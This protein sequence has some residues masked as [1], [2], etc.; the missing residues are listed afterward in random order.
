MK[1]AKQRIDAEGEGCAAIGVLYHAI[2][3]SLLLLSPIAPFISESIYQSF[4]RKYEQQESISLFGWPAAE[5]KRRDAL[6]ESRFQ[7]AREIASAAAS[8]R[9]K[10]GIPL[11]WPLEE[12][13][14]VSESTE[15]LSAVEHL[16]ALIESLSNVR[17]VKVG[18]Q[19]KTEISVQINKAKVGAAFKR[20]SPSALAALE[21]AAP[22]EIS[23][24]LSGEDKELVLEGKFAIKKDMVE[25]QE[26]SEGFAISA[27]EGG[28]AFLKTEMKKELYEEAMVREVARRVQLMRKERRLVEPDKISLHIETEDKELLSIL[29]RHTGALSSQVN[30]ETVDFSHHPGGF[31]KEWEIEDAKVRISIEKK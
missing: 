9:Q 23:K 16:S 4:Y 30:A 5:K 13:R 25:V 17:A 2:F 12:L 1:T 18:K 31:S 6:L 3:D 26:K 10:A 27:F 22:E 28:K 20:D 8:C 15:V 7:I 24:W 19:P 29:K 14:L 11:R 21:K